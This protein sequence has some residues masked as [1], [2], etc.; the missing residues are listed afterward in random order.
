MTDTAKLQ[1]VLA[2]VL[3]RWNH[4]G[5]S[6]G[7]LEA[8]AARGYEREFGAG[9]SI[10]HIRRLI[11]R[12]IERD[13]A[14]GQWDR[15]EL[16][17][18][19]KPPMPAQRRAE[20]SA[21][22]QDFA[23][24]LDVS[25]AFAEPN[26]PTPEECAEFWKA[27]WRVH[28]GLVCDGL[29][30][31]RAKEELLRFIARNVPWLS[32]GATKD[33]L[34]MLVQRKFK[35]LTHV[36]N[37]TAAIAAAAMDG[38][39][40][41]R[42]EARAEPIPQSDVDKIASFAL[43]SCG[44]R[45]AQAKR[46]LVAMGP[47]SGISPATLD[48][49]DA[50]SSKSYVNRRLAKQVHKDVQDAAP[51]ILGKRAID[52]AT[53]CLERDYSQLKS[54]KVVTA[55]DFTLPVYFSMPNRDGWFELT[56]GQCLLFIDVRSLR[57]IAHVLIPAKNYSAL[58]VRSGMNTVCFSH[59][60]PGVWYFERGLWHRSHFVKGTAPKEWSVAH[61]SGVG[62]SQ[63]WERLGVRFIH[64][65]RARS[66]IAEL[67]GGLVQNR[68]E[69]VLGYCGR[70][71][72]V[73]CPESVSK[74]KL[75]VA[76]KREHPGRH[77]HTFEGWHAELERL[78]KGYNAERQ[79]GRILGGRSPD[80][81]FEEFWPHDDPPMKPDASTWHLCAHYVREA[82]VRRDGIVFACGGN[83]YRYNSGELQQMG[84]RVMVWFDPEHPEFI[85]VTDQQHRNPILLERDMPQDFLASLEDETRPGFAAAVAKQARIVAH[86]KARYRALK[87]EFQQ[88]FRGNIVDRQ[89][90]ALGGAMLE[91]RKEAL[92][93][94]RAVETRSDRII[95][96]AGQ[97]GVPV[98]TLRDFSEETENA[99]RRRLDKRKE[100]EA[101]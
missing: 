2:P 95:R 10:R 97:L 65:T 99:L 35:K 49:M 23:E 11:K 32:E 58:H 21:T 67:V 28:S 55:D 78:I 17:A 41:Q 64:A 76:A 50:G 101:R 83:S 43:F 68:M 39:Y 84:P 80:E 24:L 19:V 59:G 72:R 26:S 56:R 36:P 54:M 9:V 31:K 25:R 7:E 51:F 66:K 8:I 15:P 37:T 87:A 42:G 73:D 60:L 74:A 33:S 13:A 91:Q 6:R 5:I 61:S 29:K 100:R 89:S 75:A 20:L 94:S 86:P 88:T 4:P 3:E 71:E 85:S 30:P 69:G 22:D 81:A 45:V 77:F 18:P 53:P 52:D 16:Y 90:A 46:E 79:D 92:A 93:V 34:R 12:A 70:N 1:R 48:L 44:G 98:G 96:Y 38:R 47:R 63:G 40:L 62:G 14:A 82:T 57:I 27:A